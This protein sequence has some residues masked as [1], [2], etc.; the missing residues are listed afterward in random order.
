M[1]NALL[2][3]TLTLS[4]PALADI[5]LGP[6]IA[7]TITDGSVRIQYRLF[8]PDALAEGARVPLILFLHGMGDRGTD[9]VSQTYWMEELQQHTRTGEHAAFLLAPQIDTNMWYGPRA[10]ARDGLPLSLAALKQVMN[11]PDVAPHL[12]ARRIYLTGVSM[13]AY[14]VWDL[15][16]REPHLFAAAI[17]M[18]G[19]GDPASAGEIL[20]PVWAFHGDADRYIHVSGSRDMFT[21]LRNAGKDA[22]YTE[23]PGGDHF[24][25]PDVFADPKHTL[26]P[27]LFSLHLDADPIWS[28]ATP[29]LQASLTLRASLTRS[30]PRMRETALVGG[31]VLAGAVVFVFR[32]RF[33]SSSISELSRRLLS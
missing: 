28:H 16:R 25:W 9:N 5:D 15:L 7:R 11:D 2:I 4:L 19:A 26:Y 29:K 12:D 18:S 14:G 33:K 13:G 8:H 10:W 1:K 32:R 24:I 27:W 31:C 30:L 21:A 23:I 17:P 6:S 3:L 22:R 20:T